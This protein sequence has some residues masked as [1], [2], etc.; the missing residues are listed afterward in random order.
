MVVESRMSVFTRIGV[1]LA[2][3]SVWLPACRPTF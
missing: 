2:G 3:S 1:F